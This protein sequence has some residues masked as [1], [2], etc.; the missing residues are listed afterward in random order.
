[1]KVDE[2]NEAPCCS[3]QSRFCLRVTYRQRASFNGACA[4]AAAAATRSAAHHF[5]RLP[6]T[7][8]VARR[9]FV[10]RQIAPPPP[11]PP[12]FLS[13]SCPLASLPSFLPSSHLLC[14][15]RAYFSSASLSRTNSSAGL[16]LS[17]GRSFAEGPAARI[18]LANC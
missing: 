4:R 11:L 17:A 8:H 12:F 2:F 16:L 14:G 3:A 18:Y 10:I 13:L 5:P 7:T 9:S 15:A 6:E 1:M